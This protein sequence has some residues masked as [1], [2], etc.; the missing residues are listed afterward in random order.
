M[1][2]LVND[3]FCLA[4]WVHTYCGTQHER[5][6][7]C[8]SLED[9]GSKLS[10]KEYWNGDKMKDI[11]KKML[12]GETIPSCHNCYNTPSALSYKYHFNGNYS[13]KLDEVLKNTDENGNYSG[14]PIAI[15]YRNSLCNLRCRMCG[16]NASTS[17]RADFANV[18]KYSHYYNKSDLLSSDESKRLEIDQLNEML[19]LIENSEVDEIYW[20]GGEPLFN[21]NHYKILEKLIELGKTDVM[22]RYNTNL[23]NLK[24]KH[25]DFIELISKFSN[26]HLYFSQDGIGEVGEYIRYG[27]KFDEWEHNL[28]KVIS[29]KKDGWRLHFHSVMTMITLLDIENILEFVE[30]KSVLSIDFFKCYVDEYK[31]LLG[32]EFYS[33]EIIQRILDDKIKLLNSKFT[34][35]TNRDITINFLQKLKA[36]FTQIPF[37]KLEWEDRVRELYRTFIYMN[38]LDIIRPYNKTFYELIGDRDVEL[39]NFLKDTNN[40]LYKTIDSIIIGEGLSKRLFEIKDLHAMPTPA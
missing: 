14:L 12:N 29:I 26:V 21:L 8:A 28:N 13:N 2:N 40:R 23:T 25:Y 33:E 15:D 39:Y 4:P 3:T 6:T 24:F 10:F 22:L 16:A 31:N 30:S 20:A 19:F 17:I 7:C 11:R 9:V 5:T 18:E 32:L 27:V 34:Q 36:E 37:Q 38:D 1:S 35:T